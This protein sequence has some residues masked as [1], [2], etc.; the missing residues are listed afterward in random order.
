MVT[1]TSDRIAEVPVAQR[2]AA[3]LVAQGV[4]PVVLDGVR[5]GE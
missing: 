3:T 1:R 2:R 5:V 4:P